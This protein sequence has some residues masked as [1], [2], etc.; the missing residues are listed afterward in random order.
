MLTYA[1]V[2][3]QQDR[4][5]CKRR[6]VLQPVKPKNKNLRNSKKVVHINARTSRLIHT[7]RMAVT[8]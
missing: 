3:R 8:A 5:S 7:A 2:C 1:D 4:R 6:A